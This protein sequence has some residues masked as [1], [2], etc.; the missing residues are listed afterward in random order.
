[1]NKEILIVNGKTYQAKEVDFNFICRLELD[2]IEFSKI[3]KK[4]MNLIKSYVA[5]CMD[6]DTEDA[7]KE[8]EQHLING[9]SFNDFNDIIAQKME[10][11]DFFRSM[12]QKKTE[13][14]NPT[15]QK[16]TRKSTAEASE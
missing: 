12:G 5:Y 13:E 4:Y 3:D 8:I 10:D 15:V 7:G 6:A 9:G 11:S 14:S 2:G 16:K 1:M